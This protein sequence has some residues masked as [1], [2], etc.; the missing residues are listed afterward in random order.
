M[1]FWPV[2]GSINI[3]ANVPFTENQP[4]KSA[5]VARQDLPEARIHDHAGS[6]EYPIDSPARMVKRKSLRIDAKLEGRT[7]PKTTVGGRPSFLFN[8]INV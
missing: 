5:G 4:G 8:R 7:H 1:Q 3:G 6:K 2:R